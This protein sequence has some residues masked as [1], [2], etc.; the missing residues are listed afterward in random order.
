[1]AD[2]K[3]AETTR[4][5]G[6]E[7]SATPVK[8][9]QLNGVCPSSYDTISWLWF[10]A[11]ITVRPISSIPYY[12]YDG[13]TKIKKMDNKKIDFHYSANLFTLVSFQLSRRV[14]TGYEIALSF[15]VMILFPFFALR[16]TL[17]SP[18]HISHVKWS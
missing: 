17:S 4:R 12:I 10:T 1:M 13:S 11:A 3:P 5:R 6:S 2:G 18:A 14:I 15:T 9:K 16:L 7:E 8:P